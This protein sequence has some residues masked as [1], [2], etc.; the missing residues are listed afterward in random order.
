MGRSA[1]KLKGYKKGGETLVETIVSFSVI[2]VMLALVGTVIMSAIRMT[3]HAAEVT[4]KLEAAALSVEQDEGGV[5][6]KAQMV[7]SQ[8]SEGG[9]LL[10]NPIYLEIDVKESGDEGHLLRYFV[11]GSGGGGTQGG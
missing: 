4:G 11:S 10:P 1:G 7:V 9:T 3:A 2:M 8:L 6:G 5:L